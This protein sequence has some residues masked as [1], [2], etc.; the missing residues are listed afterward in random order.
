[1]TGGIGGGT[2]RG[3]KGHKGTTITI[4]PQRETPR[5]W[6]PVVSLE[7]FVVQPQIGVIA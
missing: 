4:Q 3:A 5:S 7:T 6:W 2:T 1:M